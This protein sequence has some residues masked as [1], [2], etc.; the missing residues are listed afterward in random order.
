MTLIAAR[1]TPLA[2]AKMVSRK[3]GIADRAAKMSPALLTKR[4]SAEF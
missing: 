2:G 1:P 3:P 4:W